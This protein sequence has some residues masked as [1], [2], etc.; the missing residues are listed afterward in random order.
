MK[1]YKAG[2]LILSLL[3]FILV[4]MS[5]LE[6]TAQN[7]PTHDNAP[8]HAIVMHGTPALAP[9][10]DRFTYTNSRP[11]IGG[12][13]VQAQLGSFDSLNPFIVR[14][15]AAAGLRAYVFESLMAQHYDEPFALYGLLAERI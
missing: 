12:R 1:K 14:G 2:G 8:T 15:Q 3:V 7:A 10:F 6:L 13:F 11:I 4:L 5:A 9:D